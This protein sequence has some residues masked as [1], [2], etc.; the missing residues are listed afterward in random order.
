MN[1]IKI[2]DEKMRATARRGD[3]V[4]GWRL[5]GVILLGTLLYGALSWITNFTPIGGAFDGQ[6]RP[7]VAI[8]IVFGFIYGPLVGFLCGFLGNLGLDYVSGYVSYP[9]DPATGNLVRDLF[10]AYFLNWQIGNGLFG[11]IPGLWSRFY[12]RYDRV[13]DLGLAVVVSAF[14]IL[15]GTAF[16]AFID[17]LVFDYVDFDFAMYQELIPIAKINIINGIILV[18]ILLFNYE[19]LDYRALPSVRSGLMRRLLI[20]L[21]ISAAL[22]VALLGLFLVQQTAADV[23]ATSTLTL[24]LSVT[25]GLTLL[26]TVVNALLVAQTV[27]NPLMRLADAARLV[28]EDKLTQKDIDQINA[29][30]GNDE[31]TQLGH[32]FARMATEVISR[33]KKLHKQ[34]QELRIEIDRVRQEQSVTEITDSEYFQDLQGK[35]NAL[36][37]RSRNPKRPPNPHPS[38]EPV[39]V[40]ANG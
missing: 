36:R 10:A 11:L 2:H 18:P 25:A 12:P 37:Q 4:R 7:G 17:I 32:V 19:R 20:T 8:P 38:L 40:N 16:A 35:V 29:M 26:F 24:K 14:A 27:S 28:E 34:V 30:A 21:L 13:R 5:V 33:E 22:P 31:V 9:P 39:T 6:L 1:Q 3:N 15:V 23:T